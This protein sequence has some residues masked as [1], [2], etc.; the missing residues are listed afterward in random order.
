MRVFTCEWRVLPYATLGVCAHGGA[1]YGRRSG[2]GWPGR[3]RDHLSGLVVVR[4]EVTVSL[5]LVHGSIPG[6]ICKA[7]VAQ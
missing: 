4:V 1:D 6:F 7:C 3:G 5:R 2:V